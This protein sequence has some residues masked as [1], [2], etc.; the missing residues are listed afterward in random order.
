MGATEI[1]GEVGNGGQVAT[2][3]RVGNEEPPRELGR[4]KEAR[5]H[6]ADT[7]LRL[8]RGI[9]RAASGLSG[10]P[11]VIATRDPP[12]T[13]AAAKSSSREATFSIGSRSLSL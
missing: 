7:H 4:T 12:R 1:G 5:D 11:R 10:R 9:V 2:W 8:I 3:D 6:S 13:T